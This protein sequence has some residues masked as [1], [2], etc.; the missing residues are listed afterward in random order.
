MSD[1]QKHTPQSKKL[2]RDFTL[3]FSLAIRALH[4]FIIKLS[5]KSD[6]DRIKHSD[7]KLLQNY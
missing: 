3:H 2:C 1:L 5:L 7:I 6:S 4:V